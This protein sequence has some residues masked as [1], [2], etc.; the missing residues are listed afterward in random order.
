M[1]LEWTVLLAGDGAVDGRFAGVDEYGM[2]CED[3]EPDFAAVS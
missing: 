1:A 2:S 3:D